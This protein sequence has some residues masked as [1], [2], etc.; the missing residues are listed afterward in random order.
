MGLPPGP[1]LLFAC[2]SRFIAEDETQF[3]REWVERLRAAA[4]PRLRELGVLVRPHPQTHATGDT[5]GA[6]GSTLSRSGRGPAP[7]RRTRPLGAP[8]STRSSIRPASS[9]STR[10]HSSRRRSSSDRL[11]ARVRRFSLDEDGTLHFAH[12]TGDDGEDRWLS[13]RPWT[14][15]SRTRR[16]AEPA[17]SP[18]CTDRGA[19]SSR[20]SGPTASTCLAARGRRRRRGGRGSGCSSTPRTTTLRL[21][22][23]RSTVRADPGADRRGGSITSA[24]R[25]GRLG[26]ELQKP[27]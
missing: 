11:H 7:H 14:S 6:P 2:S 24:H 9:G 1:Y 13:R 22:R 15:T 27:R 5:S 10:A 18:R 25:P 16:D 21:V 8:T 12:L 3:V 26:G 19:S 4:D 20:S 17:R 23:T